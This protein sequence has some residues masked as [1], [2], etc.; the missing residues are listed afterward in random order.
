MIAFVESVGVR[1]ILAVPMLKEG[2]VIGVV[3]IYR[4]E[5]RTFTDKQVGL[6]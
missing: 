2:E 6:V 5:V 3:I 4:K 1:T